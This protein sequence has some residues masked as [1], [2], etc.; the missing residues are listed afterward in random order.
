MKPETLLELAAAAAAP[1]T[2]WRRYALGAAGVRSDGTIVV[3][4]NGNPAI[5]IPE[6]HA[7]RRL[8]RKLDR[9]SVVYV[10]RVR[11]DGSWGLAKPCKNCLPVLRARGVIQVFYTTNSGYACIRLQ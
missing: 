2:D 7:E 3:A 10:A 9:G 5:P 8:L 6:S 11:P 1:E 4:K